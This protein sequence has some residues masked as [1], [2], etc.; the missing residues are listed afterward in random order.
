MRLNDKEMKRLIIRV[1]QKKWGYTAKLLA[2]RYL[3]E[4]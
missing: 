1:I 2:G 3:K 4:L